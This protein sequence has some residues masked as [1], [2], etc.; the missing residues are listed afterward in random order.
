VLIVRVPAFALRDAA[1]RTFSRTATVMAPVTLASGV[2]SAARLLLGTAP[3]AIL[4][5]DYGRL[6]VLKTVLAA[7]ILFIGA[8]ERRRIANGK[9]PESRRVW[10]E[11]GTA[12]AVL[13]VTALL[14][15][16]EPPG[17]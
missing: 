15:G 2:G 8:G 11:L 1:W 5:S 7:V 4:A 13:L 10:V 12:G 17:E 6:L 14:T 9:T 16:S 3:S